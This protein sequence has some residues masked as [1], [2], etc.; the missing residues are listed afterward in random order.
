MWTWRRMENGQSLLTYFFVVCVCVGLG[1]C[2]CVMRVFV[3]Y[4]VAMYDVVRVGFVHVYQVHVSK[5]G[6]LLMYV[7]VNAHVCYVCVFPVR[8]CEVRVWYLRVCADRR[9][10]NSTCL[11]QMV[12]CFS[13]KSQK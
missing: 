13:E 8:V 7:F 4:L 11:L 5:C 3:I 2:M 10:C 6:C 12:S 1:V 9:G